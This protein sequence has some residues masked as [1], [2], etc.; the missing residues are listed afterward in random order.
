MFPM[1]VPVKRKFISNSLCDFVCF[2]VHFA[3]P[4]SDKNLTLFHL[5]LS[6]PDVQLAYQTFPLPLEETIQM[7]MTRSR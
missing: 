7:E 2:F 5:P 3:A 4:F 6:H 1:L